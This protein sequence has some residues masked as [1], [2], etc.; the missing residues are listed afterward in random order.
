M[1]IAARFCGPPDSANGG[2]CAGLL[3][4]AL[5]GSVEVTLRQPPPLERP[6]RLQ[7][8]HDR[9]FLRDD[10]QLVAEARRAPL[11]L[12]VPVPPSFVKARES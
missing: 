4:G 11:D 3:A 7:V 8:E 10:T 1:L 2:Y 6:L 9:A 12:A 5:D